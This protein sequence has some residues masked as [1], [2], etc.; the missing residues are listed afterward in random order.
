M[1]PPAGPA[2][3]RAV[4]ELELPAGIA[5]S[6]DGTP[7]GDRRR[8]EFA[9]LTNGWGETHEVRA[10]FSGGGQR[11]WTVYVRGGWHVRLPIPAPDHVRPELALQTGHGA[12]IEAAA[13]STDGKRL[14]TGGGGE[15]IL[16]DVVTGRVLRTY[17]AVAGS[18][19]KSV[20]FHPN[21]QEI[22]IASRTGDIVFHDPASGR[23]KRQF[24]HKGP[25]DLLVAASLSPDGRHVLTVNQT[26]CVWWDAAVGRRI[27]TLRVPQSGSTPEVHDAIIFPDGKRALIGG[28]YVKTFIWDLET[29]RHE[30]PFPGAD[31]YKLALS[32]DGRQACLTLLMETTATIYDL[33]SG[34]AAKKKVQ[35]HSPGDIRALTFTRDGKQLVSSLNDGTAIVWNADTGASLSQHRPHSSHPV[36]MLAHPDGRTIVSAG[37]DK[38]PVRWDR[39]TGTVVTQFA[40]Q[41]GG[42]S[43]I[44]FS[45]DGGLLATVT[46]VPLLIWDLKA[47]TAPTPVRGVTGVHSV[48]ARPKPT[49]FGGL[50]G[51]TKTGRDANVID[52]SEA[53]QVRSWAISVPPAPRPQPGR[54]GRPSY[55]VSDVGRYLVSADGS[56]IFAW[57]GGGTDVWD[58]INERHVRTLPVDITTVLEPRASADGRLLL[59]SFSPDDKTVQLWSADQGKLLHTLRDARR[60]TGEAVTPDNKTAITLAAEHTFIRWDVDTGRPVKEIPTTG[61]VFREHRSIVTPD[62]RRL[63]GETED[64]TF[65]VF[66]L[67]S[68]RALHT[69]RGH[70]ATADAVAVSPDGRLLAA[71]VSSVVWVWDL[72][73]GDV[74]ACLLSLDRGKDW[75]A[76]TPDGLFDGSPAGREQVAFRVGG[77]LNVVPVDRFFQDFY[78]PGLLAEIVKGDR[79][80]PEVRLGQQ[81]PPTVKIVSPAQG[82][83]TQQGEV[84]IEAEVTDAGGGIQ[85]P[86]LVHNGITIRTPGRSE[87]RGTSLRRT[88]QLQLAPGENVIQVQAASADGSWKSE[89][90]TLTLRYEKPAERVNL[91]LLSVGVSRYADSSLNL[92]YAAA[93][94]KAIATL[95]GARGKG[96]FREVRPRTLTDSDGT[97]D[98]IRKAVQ[99]IA[100]EARPEDVLVVFLAGHGTSLGSRYYYVP[101]DFRRT[102]SS[103]V[104]DDVRKQGLAGDVLASWLEEVRAT[105][106]V[107]VF[108]TCQS[109]AAV[110]LKH[111]GRDPF[112]FQGAIERIRHANGAHTIAAAAAGEEAKELDE[113][114][115]GLLTYALL[116]GVR[117][118]DRGP[119]AD[120]P[121]RTNN[122]DEVVDVSEWFSYASGNV[123]RLAE[124]YFKARQNVSVC[125]S[126]NI[127]PL[128]PL[129]G[130]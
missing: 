18:V 78:R 33:S 86:W 64:F 95:F 109:G 115:H 24:R 48:N 59:F 39:S 2:T 71:S 106:R 8:F 68:G 90:A 91:Y 97:R 32:H 126:E 20:A 74:V 123:P 100:A 102:S 58:A 104:E 42:I 117:A 83:P 36:Q 47:G 130:R 82:G 127:F 84:T 17:P 63:I 52:A 16:W 119:L 112:G 35:I 1:V 99:A 67:E 96:L 3:D 124:R 72:A 92:K 28:F 98:N 34:G 29:G 85:G 45:A 49:E 65:V 88:F 44:A 116:A 107:V 87:R 7:V 9:G 55:L 129:E 81:T 13:L 51:H 73:T 57:R 46:G 12:I 5:V 62:G 22:M 111:A 37:V 89:S 70:N 31:A 61:P 56:R 113:L 21:G 128:L 6:L 15:A 41:P 108:D 14:L 50:L 110:G 118:V 101:H 25:L 60:I 75:L 40:G 54:I 27:H 93:D 94:A 125:C 10:T 121:I 76:V 11:T 43:S 77:G 66:D 38:R 105:K 26:E 23:V 4:L 103:P 122:P 69:L 19:V 53:K 120:R 80:K 30:H 79:P 114:G